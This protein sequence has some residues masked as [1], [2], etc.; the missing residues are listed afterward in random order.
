MTASQDS[1]ATSSVVKESLVRGRHMYNGAVA[2]LIV[3]S[4]Q[5]TAFNFK[6]TSCDFLLRHRSCNSDD[7]CEVKFD[8][9]L[10]VANEHKSVDREAFRVD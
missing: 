6:E 4:A 3:F 10:A 1:H 8:K 9:R 2:F 7:S 5:S